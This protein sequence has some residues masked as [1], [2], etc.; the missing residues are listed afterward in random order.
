MKYI[1]EVKKVESVKVGERYESAP[2]QMYRERGSSTYP[3][4]EDQ[5]S[6]VLR[7]EVENLNMQEL[8]KLLNGIV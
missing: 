1:I 6:L 4:M 8:V 2:D 3:I 7:Q 5:V